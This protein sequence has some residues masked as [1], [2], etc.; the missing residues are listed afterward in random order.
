MVNWVRN[1]LQNSSGSC[2]GLEKDLL[3]SI[4]LKNSKHV[5]D[6]KKK[7]IDSSGFCF[8]DIF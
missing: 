2:N 1:M 5:L 3:P 6:K 7:K 4:S 8:G